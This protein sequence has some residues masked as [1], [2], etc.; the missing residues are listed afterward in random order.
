[1]KNTTSDF[2]LTINRGTL[3]NDNAMEECHSY[4]QTQT[5]KTE[6]GDDGFEDPDGGQKGRSIPCD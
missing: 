4:F 1:M 6:D 5:R 3:S 2:S